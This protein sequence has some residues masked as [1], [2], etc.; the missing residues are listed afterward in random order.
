MLCMFICH[1]NFLCIQALL[2]R[3][4]SQKMLYSLDHKVMDSNDVYIQVFT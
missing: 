1:Q 2:K 3:M 4:V